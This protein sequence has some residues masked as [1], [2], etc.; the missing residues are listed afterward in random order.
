MR[1]KP[2]Q[3]AIGAFESRHLA[4]GAMQGHNLVETGC[5]CQPGAVRVRTK[6]RSL[7]CIN[8]LRSMTPAEIG[9]RLLRVVAILV[10]RA[11]LAGSESIP[12]PDLAAAPR[13]WVHAT[14]RVDAAQ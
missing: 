7:W 10:E 8:R 11:G 13:P 4:T 6:E 5:P 2:E 14:A 12:P 9:H 3:A 1:K